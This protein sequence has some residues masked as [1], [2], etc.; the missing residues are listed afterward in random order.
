MAFVTPTKNMAIRPGQYRSGIAAFLSILQEVF[1]REPPVV[2]RQDLP[3]R[4]PSI[5]QQSTSFAPPIPPLPPELGNSESGSSNISAGI[6]P[7]PPPRPPKTDDRHIEYRPHQANGAPP[8]PPHPSDLERSVHTPPY[9]PR[10]TQQGTAN[11]GSSTSYSQ[12]YHPSRIQNL[13]NENGPGQVYRQQHQ[14]VPR[15]LPPQQTASPVSPMTPLPHQSF[16][17]RTLPNPSYAMPMQAP[18]QQQLRNAEQNSNQNL[19]QQHSEQFQPQQPS[20]QRSPHP[21]PQKPKPPEDLLTSPFE[22]TLPTPTT[23]IAPPPIPPNPQKDAIL[24]ALSEIL[25]QQIQ[26]THAS[27]MSAI[28]PLRAQQAALNETLNKINQEMSQLHDLQALLDSNERILRQA[29]V[30]ADKVLNDA[31]HRDVPAVEDVLVA[32]TVVAG[33]LYENVIEAQVLEDCRAVVAKALD[34]GRI[35]GDVWAKVRLH[36]SLQI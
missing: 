18:P 21:Q 6:Q 29:M 28:P 33:Q 8:V 16:P 31:K 26:S 20:F 1:A 25:T 10:I 14:N 32:P 23:E 24:N 7:S 15:P 35:S 11:P 34:K 12:Q 13:R 19:W 2:S 5:P 36:E 22:T 27:N 4:P 3:P 30:D 9:V 17:G